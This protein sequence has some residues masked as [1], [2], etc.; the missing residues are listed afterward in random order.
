M[1]EYKL[2]KELRKRN[3]VLMN[4]F[5][6]TLDLVYIYIVSLNLIKQ[7][8]KHKIRL[9]TYMPFCDFQ[10][11]VQLSSL[12]MCKFSLYKRQRKGGKY[13]E[14]FKKQN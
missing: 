7:L 2:L 13:N 11:C 3:E 10:K 6:E 5:A 9:F 8:Y 12:F 14:E 1:L 4:K